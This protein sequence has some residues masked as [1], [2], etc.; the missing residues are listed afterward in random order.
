MI[1]PPTVVPVGERRFGSHESDGHEIR[2]NLD[3]SATL[4][5][6]EPEVVHYNPHVPLY[7]SNHGPP[8]FWPFDAQ[9][10]VSTEHER[11][12]PLW[13]SRPVTR[14]VDPVAPIIED[15]IVS[16]PPPPAVAL[17]TAEQHYH[18]QSLYQHQHTPH[19]QQSIEFGSPAPS[20]PSSSGPLTPDWRQRTT[21]PWQQ[22][23]HPG[24]DYAFAHT[25][26]PAITTPI[27]PSQGRS[28]PGQV[29]E[30]WISMESNEMRAGMMGV[31]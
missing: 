26:P 2:H 11:E 16:V 14:N 8:Q 27:L 13:H 22:L 17:E 10:W 24:H 25:Y 28:H 19:V 1:S 20:V 15:L 31:R 21:Q 9:P 30:H 6:Q 5:P 18:W 12:I 23:V 29:F 3:T 4:L 7:K